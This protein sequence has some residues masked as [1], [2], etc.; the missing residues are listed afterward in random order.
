MVGVIAVNQRSVDRPS[1]AISQRQVRSCP[2]LVLEVRIVSL[3]P[4]VDNVPAALSVTPGNAEQEVRPWV[5]GRVETPAAEAEGTVESRKEWVVNLEAAHIKPELERVAARDVAEVVAE[6]VGLVNT[7]LRAVGGEP[8][9]EETRHSGSWP[10]LVLGRLHVDPGKTDGRGIHNVDRSHGREI[11]PRVA[12]AR[13]VERC[14]PKSVVPA[15]HVFLDMTL[16]RVGESRQG[17]ARE[18]QRVKRW[19]DLVEPVAPDRVLITEVVI[20]AADVLVSLPRCDGSERILISGVGQ[21]NEL[22]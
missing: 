8:Q 16:C 4:G 12:D 3:R 2:K 14:W 22:V 10:A 5:S 19:V 9:C 6:L 13:L 1:R 7:G 15:K 17:R 20:N 21:R 18:R 11:E